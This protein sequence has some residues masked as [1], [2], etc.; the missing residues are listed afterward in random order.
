MDTFV[1]SQRSEIMRRVRSSGT[2]P[3]IIV[4]KILRGIR[5]KY[6]SCPRNVVGKPDVVILGQQKAIFVHGCFWHGGPC[7]AHA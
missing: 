3:E 4:R 1:P 5:I 7:E 2:R 6:R